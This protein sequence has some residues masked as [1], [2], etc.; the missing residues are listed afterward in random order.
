MVEAPA[1]RANGLTVRLG[2]TKAPEGVIGRVLAGLVDGLEGE[3][4]GRSRE[5][6]WEGIAIASSAYASH[7][8]A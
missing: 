2:P 8:M 7:M 5:E 4:T 6:K 3:G 1:H